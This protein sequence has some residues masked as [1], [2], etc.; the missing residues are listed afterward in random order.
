MDGRMEGT[1]GWR[2]TPNLPIFLGETPQ[3]N[4]SNLA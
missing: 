1:E 2:D 4:T 3:Q